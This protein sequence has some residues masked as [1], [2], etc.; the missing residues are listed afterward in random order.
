[1]K[2]KPDDDGRMQAA[3]FRSLR[4]PRGFTLVELM[5]GILVL[6]ILTAVAVPGFTNMVNRN[7]LAAESNDLLSAIQFARMEAIRSSAQVTFCGTSDETA[8]DE[9]DCETGAQPF[10]VVIGPADSGKEQLRLYE[11]KK[12][13]DVNTEL[14]KITFSGDGLARDAGT[15]ALVKGTITV[16]LP[17]KNPAQNKRVLTI[18]SGARVVISTPAEDGKGACS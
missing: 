16:C 1:M 9:A 8:S 13:L 14:E 7:R 18:T 4:R 10:W 6:G 11:A 17:T 3:A 15:K 2:R 12:P 5:T